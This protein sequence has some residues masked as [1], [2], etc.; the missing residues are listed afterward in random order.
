MYCIFS[1]NLNIFKYNR[2]HRRRVT[3]TQCNGII[4]IWVASGSVV[5]FFGGRG[6]LLKKKKIEYLLFLRI[7]KYTKNR[8]FARFSEN[9]GG[10]RML[11][12]FWKQILV[13][14][15][16]KLNNTQHCIQSIL[17]F[18]WKKSVHWFVSFFNYFHHF[19]KFGHEW[20]WLA[21]CLKCLYLYIY[22][23]NK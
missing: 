4:N 19:T 15:L 3:C 10:K 11:N 13:D 2:G 18:F 5:F 9:K 6:C 23:I 16:S 17:L 14:K 12:S 7:Y 20:G 8:V 1:F 21:G 22:D